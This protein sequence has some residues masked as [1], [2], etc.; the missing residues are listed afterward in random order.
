MKMKGKVQSMRKRVLLF[1]LVFAFC[2][3]M[4]A[5]ADFEGALRDANSEAI[6]VEEDALGY[7]EGVD[8]ISIGDVND[9]DKV[10]AVAIDGSIISLISG[11]KVIQQ[12]E[13][14]SSFEY[15]KINAIVNDIDNDGKNEII[16]MASIGGNDPIYCLYLLDMV[17][18]KYEL[19]KFPKEI[20]TLKTNTGIDAQ[21]IP[22]DFLKYEIRGE[23]FS[24]TIDVSRTYGVST[25][26]EQQYRQL[27]DLWEEIL[28]EE[29]EGQIAGVV[30]AEVITNSDGKKVI[31]AY[32]MINGADK[33][34][35]GLLVV[36]IAFNA[37]GEYQVVNYGLFEHSVLMP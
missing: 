22:T 35:I 16:V 30:R 36:D 18:Q 28:E 23:D 32:E 6:N 24:F 37:E 3:N 34:Y 4:V 21:V 8:K 1:I 29:K 20:L 2:G 26:E 19:V 17:E 25:M 14:D 5:C 7:I 31:R 13:P 9:D 11:N 15:K 27:I 12:F 33:S 10:D